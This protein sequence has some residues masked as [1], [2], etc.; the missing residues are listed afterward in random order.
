[1]H[2]LKIKQVDIFR[3]S[4]NVLIHAFLLEDKFLVQDVSTRL[5]SIIGNKRTSDTLVAAI[6]ELSKNQPQC[7]RWILANLSEI[8]TFTALLEKVETNHKKEDIM[9]SDKIETFHLNVNLVIQTLKKRNKQL[10]YSFEKSLNLSVGY[11]YT[12]EVFIASLFE[13]AEIDRD[14]F[15]WTI[16]NLYDLEFYNQ[17]I[18]LVISFAAK[19]LL[20]KG[21][22]LGKDF[23]A[24]CNSILIS[25]KANNALMESDLD[26]EDRIL[27]QEILQV[28]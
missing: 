2:H 14:T 4:L 16:K 20:D 26:P 27:L 18:K 22:I 15:S 11:D 1:M 28:F 12:A 24:T 25:Q 13:L 17:L 9:N 21:F 8:E 10:L 23:S 7:F 19:T 5:A 3:L 6:L